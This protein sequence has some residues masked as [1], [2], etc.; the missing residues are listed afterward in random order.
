MTVRARLYDARGEDQELDLA[1]LDLG[2]VDDKKLL[3]IDIDDRDDKDIDALVTKLGLGPRIARQLQPE[4]RRPRLVREPDWIALTLN[5]VERDGDAEDG[6]VTQRDLDLVA[7]RN[8][9][10]TAHDG[11]LK[12]VDHVD[13]QLRDERELGLLD[14]GALLT[15]LID[16]MIA[17]YLSEV[18]A[19]EREIDHLDAIALRAPADHDTFLDEVVALRRRIAVIRRS[20]TPNRE[21][22]VP[23]VRPD[24]DVRDDS[25][26]IWPGTVDRLERAIDAV[27]NARELLVGSFDIY[28]GRAAQRSND[29]MKLLTLVSAIALPAIVLAGVMGMN[30]KVPFFDNANNYF[31]V[32]GSM[33]VFGLAIVGIA[34]WRRWI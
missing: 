21:A 12:A 11:P 9:V 10:V 32:V 18:E 22:L 20:L 19:I 31:L 1:D 30:F 16:A 4:R 6:R 15:S 27:E 26:K 14:A 13:D 29:V 17:G 33:I 28:M 8:L 23:L 24:F 3:W 2:K 5:G 25:L 34:R 7:G